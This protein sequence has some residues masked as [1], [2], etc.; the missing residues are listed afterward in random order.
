MRHQITA[1]LIIGSLVCFPLLAQE[2]LT[3]NT[4]KLSTDAPSASVSDVSWLK[5]NW[6]SKAGNTTSTE[7]WNDPALGIMKGSYKAFTGNELSAYQILT[8]YEESGKLFLKIQQVKK[9]SD[10]KESIE[11]TNVYPLVKLIISK[12][13]FEGITFEQVNMNRLIIYSAKKIPNGTFDEHKE[14]F[15]RDGADRCLI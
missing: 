14:V 11:T 8:I 5:G 3:V 12:A 15:F 7:I 13:F 2:K 1:L 6:T 9:E 4:L 10:G